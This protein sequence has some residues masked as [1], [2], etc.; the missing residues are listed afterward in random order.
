MGRWNVVDPLAEA[1][2]DLSPYNYAVNNPIL[3]IDPTGMAADTTFWGG[4]LE[5]VNIVGNKISNFRWPTSTYIIPI[6][7]AA[8]ES[9]NNL[10][11]GN[12]V[13]S[14][15][16]FSTSLA[17][18]FTAGYLSQYRIGTKMMSSTADDIV[19]NSYKFRQGVKEAF[20]KHALAN[21]RHND[22]GVSGETLVE[23]AFNLIEK[24]ISKLKPGDNTLIGTI[25]GIQKSFKAFVKDG[26]IMSVNM[27]PQISNRITTGEI[28][29]FGNILW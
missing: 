16:N 28:I 8:A 3:M 14:L 18:L 2:D 12:Y 9:G 10:A 6:F 21:G 29:K 24:N 4:V 15:G 11:D 25:N 17:E 5:T 22:L 1:F 19:I 20:K 27:Y 13:A 23:N 26:E 7:G